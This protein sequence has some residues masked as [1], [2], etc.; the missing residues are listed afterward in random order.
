MTEQNQPSIDKTAESATKFLEAIQSAMVD[1]GIAPNLA[2]SLFGYFARKVIDVEVEAGKN[3]A[4]VTMAFVTS[5]M[6][7]TGVPT[8]FKRVDGEQAQQAAAE[9]LRADSSAKVH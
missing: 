9:F 4:D 8:A 2:I 5:F 6:H 7:G 3:R 1:L